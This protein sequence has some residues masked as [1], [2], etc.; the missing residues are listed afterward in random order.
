M[1][2]FL[3]PFA[4]QQSQAESILSPGSLD[5]SHYQEDKGMGSGRGHQCL[6]LTGW[7]SSHLFHVN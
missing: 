3:K 6:W 1:G 2:C 5:S 7:N 4:S